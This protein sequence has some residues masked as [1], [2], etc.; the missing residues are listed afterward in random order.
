LCLA[1]SGDLRGLEDLGGLT[2]HEHLT[3]AQNIIAETGYHRRDGEIEALAAQL[4]VR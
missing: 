1:T 4:A 2:A 3:T